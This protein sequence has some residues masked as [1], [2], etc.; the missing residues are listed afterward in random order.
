MSKAFCRT[1]EADALQDRVWEGRGSLIT[2]SG[3]FWEVH[4]WVCAGTQ[5]EVLEVQ[6]WRMADAVSGHRSL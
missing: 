5:G 4:A 1:R 6:G 2:S 3:A